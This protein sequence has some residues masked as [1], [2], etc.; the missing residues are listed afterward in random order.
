MNPFDKAM[1][2]LLGVL[3]CLVVASLAVPTFSHL[4]EIGFVPRERLYAVMIRNAFLNYA[5]ENGGNFPNSLDALDSPEHVFR[6]SLSIDLMDSQPPRS[7]IYHIGL[8]SDSPSTE[9]ALISP[10]LVNTTATRS[11]R[12]ARERAGGLQYPPEKPV[13]VLVRVDGP[14]ESMTEEEFQKLVDDGRIVLPPITQP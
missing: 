8:T 12:R 4:S 2:W 7:W 3:V 13:R 14:P 6:R 5:A 10:P 11:E 1:V 9:W